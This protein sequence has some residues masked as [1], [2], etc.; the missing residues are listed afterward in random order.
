MALSVPT[1]VP[2]QRERIKEQR[3]EKKKK[4]GSPKYI[5]PLRKRIPAAAPAKELIDSWAVQT[6]I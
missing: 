6:Y 4:K 1:R 5:P 2:E 3:R